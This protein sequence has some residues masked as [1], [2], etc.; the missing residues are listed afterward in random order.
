M[1]SQ[2]LDALVDGV[3]RGDSALIAE[4]LGRVED[5]RPEALPHQRTLLGRLEN[6]TAPEHAVVGL[7]GPPGV[8]KSS[9]AAALIRHWLDEGLG[10]GMVDVDP[11]MRRSGGALLGVRA[12]LR[13]KPDDRV[14]IR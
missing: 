6:E 9:L 5:A 8:G 2:K 10:V 13:P 3:C 14:F 12:R 4:T 1:T 11:T 7:T